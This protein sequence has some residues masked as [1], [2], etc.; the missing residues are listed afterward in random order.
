MPKGISLFLKISIAYDF[1]IVGLGKLK[2]HHITS[3]VILR[4]SD[5]VNKLVFVLLA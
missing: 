2:S 4:T 3:L 5:Y 1:P